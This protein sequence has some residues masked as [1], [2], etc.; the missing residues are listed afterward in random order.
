MQQFL[1]TEETFIIAYIHSWQLTAIAVKQSTAIW[2]HGIAD[3]LEAS[4]CVSSGCRWWRWPWGGYE[5]SCKYVDEACTGILH[6]ERQ[7]L[8]HGVYSLDLTKLSFVWKGSVK[9]NLKE[10]NWG[11]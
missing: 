6:T 5:G 7:V 2:L 9:M 10:M 11:D 3:L 8:Q 1:G 4:G